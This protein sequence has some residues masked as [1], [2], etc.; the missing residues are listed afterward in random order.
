MPG[1]I[2]VHKDAARSHSAR[3]VLFVWMG[4]SIVRPGIKLCHIVLCCIYCTGSVFELVN[5]VI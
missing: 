2:D 4:D 1:S 3:L 5:L